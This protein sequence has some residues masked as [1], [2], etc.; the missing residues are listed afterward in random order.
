M[1]NQKP[2]DY[3]TP[4]PPGALRLFGLFG[5]LL[6]VLPFSKGLANHTDTLFFGPGGATNLFGF[7]Y[8]DKTTN[9]GSIPPDGT[10]DSVS[11]LGTN[12]APFLGDKGASKSNI[13]RQVYQIDTTNFGADYG[14]HQLT[15]INFNTV[16]YKAVGA[17]IPSDLEVYYLSGLAAA[18]DINSLGSA[19]DWDLS[20]LGTATL[21]GAASGPLTSLDTFIVG[22]IPYTPTPAEITAATVSISLDSQLAAMQNDITAG[23]RLT[24]VIG[25]SVDPYSVLNDGSRDVFEYSA[26]GG[27]TGTFGDI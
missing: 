10:W 25:T 5:V 1:R 17:M 27:A 11:G 26:Y 7:E 14:G 18:P 4:K 16:L 2:S 20:A 23:N 22:A 13:L 15:G 9:P 12:P 3:P 19:N 24:F 21:A 6:C 8:N